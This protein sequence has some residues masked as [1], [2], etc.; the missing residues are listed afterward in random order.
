MVLGVRRESSD[1]EGNKFLR[2]PATNAQIFKDNSQ[3]RGTIKDFAKAAGH[4]H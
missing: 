4:E 1:I 2:E 3:S